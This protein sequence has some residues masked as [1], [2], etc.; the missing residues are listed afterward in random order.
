MNMQT[1]IDLIKQ[2]EP[3]YE[4]TY[5][6]AKLKE[7]ACDLR[8]LVRVKLTT[9]QHTALLSLIEDIGIYEFTNAKI[10]EFINKENF[11]L[12]SAQFSNYAKIGRVNSI[13]KVKRRMTERKLFMDKE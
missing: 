10:L 5:L 3:K 11:I 9:K 1:A 13:R 4:D 2:F 6:E 8:S 7:I 12:A